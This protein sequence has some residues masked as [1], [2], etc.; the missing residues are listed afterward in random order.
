MVML[1]TIQDSDLRKYFDIFHERLN[2]FFPYM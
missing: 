1:S 2:K